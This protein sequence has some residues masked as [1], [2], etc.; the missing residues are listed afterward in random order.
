M[1]TVN[2]KLIQEV[3]SPFHSYLLFSNFSSELVK[4]AKMFAMLLAF[5]SKDYAEHPDINIIDSENINTLGVEDIRD[6][7]NKDSLSPIEGRYKVVIFPPVKSL[8]EEASNALLKTIE[9]P[10]SRSIFIILSSG[11]FWSHARD[12]S[13][14]TI[15]STIKSRCRTIFL[16]SENE[17]KFD[18]STLD[19]E[20]FL[21][22]TYLNLD[23]EKN[24]VEKLQEA[25]QDLKEIN[26][27][28]SERIKR[29]QIFLNTINEFVSNFDET[30]NIT[31]NSVLIESLTY[32][33]SSLIT[34]ENLDQ[35]YYDFI[36]KL[37]IAMQEISSGMRPQI[38]LSNLTINSGSNE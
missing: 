2:K 18:F 21:D 34:Q 32:L 20:K 27:T 10:S 12:D 9:E 17:I 16:E 11:K 33:G 31:S 8:T 30:R 4:Q 3:K 19:F 23:I 24:L 28:E 35:G 37:E 6:V 25:T 15:L 38:V 7:I 13:Q 1:T 26:E 36:L 5:D 29:Y 14:N 22:G